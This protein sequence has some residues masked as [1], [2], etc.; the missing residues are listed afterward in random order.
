VEDRF[1]WDVRDYEFSNISPEQ[2]YPHFK[3]DFVEGIGLANGE[4]LDPKYGRFA[5]DLVIPFDYLQVFS[6]SEKPEEWSDSKGMTF[7]LPLMIADCLDVKPEFKF[8]N[9]TASS[10]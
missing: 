10:G 2:V 4:P 1:T 9:S 3:S 7:E 8:S 5:I 6:D